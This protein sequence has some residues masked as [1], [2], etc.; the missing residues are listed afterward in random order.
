MMFRINKIG[1]SNFLDLLVLK[2]KK[3]SLLFYYSII[4][5]YI[6]KYINFYV[7]II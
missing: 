3:L 5:V 4:V 6:N 2:V 1:D 7:F